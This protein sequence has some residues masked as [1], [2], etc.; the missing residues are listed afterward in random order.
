[1]SL[2]NRRSTASSG[3]GPG[4]E[5]GTRSATAFGARS[6]ARWAPPRTRWPPPW[7]PSPSRRPTPSARTPA[8]GT[9][10]GKRHLLTE[11]HGLPIDVMVTSAGLHD[12]KP[13]RDLLTRARRP[14]PELAIVLSDS[15][16]RGPFAEWARTELRLTVRTVSRSKD[17]KGFVV[18]PRR[19]VAER[20]RGWVMHARRLVRDHERLPESSEAMINLAAIRL[21]TRRLTRPPVYPT[22]ARPR[23]GSLLTAA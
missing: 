21:M 16:Y 4:P 12:S 6:A 1:M 3:A 7:T 9:G 22:A 18:L 2:L 11:T 15:A 19:W 5:S 23:P 17:A 8:V 20:T 14:H 10:G 13:A